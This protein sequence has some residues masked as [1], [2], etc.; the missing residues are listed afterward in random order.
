MK[1][2]KGGKSGLRGGSHQDTP[3]IKNILIQKGERKELIG[4]T[5]AKEQKP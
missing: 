4:R 1:K 3:K 2:L 5:R